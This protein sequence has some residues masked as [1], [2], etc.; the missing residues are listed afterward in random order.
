MPITPEILEPVLSE[1]I[2][3]PLLF[4]IMLFLRVILQGLPAAQ[5]LR[6][7]IVMILL[8]E[9]LFLFQTLILKATRL[10]WLAQTAARYEQA[11][12]FR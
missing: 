5:F 9:R 3:I 8:W 2:M 7:I 12:L 1:P 11:A 6:P 10:I 4:W